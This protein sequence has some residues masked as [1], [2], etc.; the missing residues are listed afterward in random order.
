VGK[1][2]EGF[3]ESQVLYTT[4]KAPYRESVT[5]PM[6]NRQKS[7]KDANPALMLFILFTEKFGS[8]FLRTCRKS[9]AAQL[10]S[11]FSPGGEEKRREPFQL[12]AG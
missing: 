1:N 3:P 10:Y 7:G 2:G 12:Q 5:G 8:A 9:G 4:D 6:Y 11:G